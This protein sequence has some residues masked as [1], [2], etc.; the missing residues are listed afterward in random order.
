MHAEI[1]F[2]FNSETSQDITVLNR[3]SARTLARLLSPEDRKVWK[4]RKN[5]TTE[6]MTVE[7]CPEV[8]DFS[9]EDVSQVEEMLAFESELVKAAN[10]MRPAAANPNALIKA[11]E[12]VE[13]EPIKVP[14]ILKMSEVSKEIRRAP[15]APKK[16]AVKIPGP[17]ET[18]LAVAENDLGADL[19][20]S[21]DE[22]PSAAPPLRRSRSIERWPQPKEPTL[23]STRECRF[24]CVWC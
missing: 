13:A 16:V 18:Q 1:W 20:F 15:V 10:T 24:I 6:V 2:F 12:P 9:T 22:T 23:A 3:E 7:N 17:A 19:G 4:V 11:P 8:L 5:R 14:E 21:S